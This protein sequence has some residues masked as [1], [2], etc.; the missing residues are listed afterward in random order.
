[1]E[2]ILWTSGFNPWYGVVGV[3]DEANGVTTSPCLY[4]FAEQSM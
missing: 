1:M 2:Y 4:Y 3:E